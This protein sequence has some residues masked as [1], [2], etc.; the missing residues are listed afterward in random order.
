MQNA[1]VYMKTFSTEASEKQNWFLKRAEAAPQ[2]GSSLGA[3]HSEQ[4]GSPGKYLSFTSALLPLHSPEHPFWCQTTEHNFDLSL[5]TRKL[6]F[7][8]KDWSLNLHRKVIIQRLIPLNW[9]TPKR[10]SL[11]K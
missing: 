2:Q 11:F 4:G 5:F 3:R 10:L 1:L 7:L 6:H 8:W 9:V